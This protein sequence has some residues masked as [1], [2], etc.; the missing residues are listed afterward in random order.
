MSRRGNCLDN[1]AMES[2]NSTLKSE[3]SEHFPSQGDAKAQLFD[4]IEVFY[5][6]QRRHSSLGYLSPA[7][8]ERAAR[9]AAAADAGSSSVNTALQTATGTRTAL[10]LGTAGKPPAPSNALSPP[11]ASAQIDFT[12]TKEYR[13]QHDLR[14]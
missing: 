7:Q 14:Q 2:F 1:A 6:Q 10:L 13:T 11:I 4:Y 5:N 12:S 8:Y 9:G 3:L